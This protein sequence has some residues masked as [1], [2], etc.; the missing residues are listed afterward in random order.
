MARK[1]RRV[2]LFIRDNLAFSAF[3]ALFFHLNFKKK[4]N[5]FL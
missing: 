1:Q 3:F 2:N 5:Y 4:I